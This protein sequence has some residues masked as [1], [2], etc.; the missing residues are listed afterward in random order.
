MSKSPV[1]GLG[2]DAGGTRTR[3]ALVDQQGQLLTEG[4]VAGMGGLQLQSD[5]GL[6]SLRATL[7]DLSDAV[8]RA[9]QGRPLALYSGFTGLGSEQSK[10]AMLALLR[11]ALPISTRHTTISH[12]M[13]IA[14]RAAF[15]PGAG[16]LVY[17]GTGSVAAFLEAQGQTHLA[18]GRGFLLGDDG[19]GY[20]IAREALAWV[21]RQEDRTPGA[22]KQSPMAQRLFDAVGGSDWKFTRAFA[23]GS[24][25][26]A[27]GRLALQVGASAN[28]DPAAHAL[29]LRAGAALGELA[30]H[31][32]HRFGPRPI[33]AAG[34][35]MLLSP[36]LETGLRQAL[37]PD[38][39][40][41]ITPDLAAHVTAARLAIFDSQ[42]G[43]QSS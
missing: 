4:H 3:W 15:A 22:W 13:D 31:M 25:R 37:P 21:W 18:G 11:E 14:Y 7:H 26:G 30:Q 29:L 23:Y 32:L 39:E 20:W 6:A 2:L 9:V 27:M 41:R 34:R 5:A 1:L 24:D 40:L 17:A 19:G 42:I 38:T 33:T 36:L 28:D 43:I 35:A 16:Y 12:D 10:S 8:G